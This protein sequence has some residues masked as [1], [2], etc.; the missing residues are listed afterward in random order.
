MQLKNRERSSVRPLSVAVAGILSLAAFA[1]SAQESA[2]SLMLD[3]IVVTAQKRAA[4]LQ[5]VPLSVAAV[6]GEKMVDAGIKDLA[7]MAGYV[8]NFEKADTSIGQYLI[9]RGIG[10]GIN[11]GFEQSVVQY[12]DDVALGRS[13]LARMPFM[14]LDRIEVLR[15]P[16]N[17]LFGKNSIAGALSIVTAKPTS[18]LTGRVGVEYEPEYNGREGNLVI[19]GA[20]SDNIRGRL[21]ARYYEED[22]YFKNNLTGRDE[23][24]RK[25]TAIRGTLA[26]DITDTL[27]ATLKYEHD[28]FDYKGRTDEMLFTY[29]NPAPT[30]PFYGLTYPQIAAALGAMVGQDIGSDDGRQDF[31]RNSNIDEWSNNEVNVATLTANWNLGWSTLTAVSGYA[32]YKIDENNDTDASGIDVF[33]TTQY[34][35]YDQFSQEIRLVSPGGEKIDW[36]VGAYYQDWNLK[37]RA[38]LD[39]DGQNLFTALGALGGPYAPLGALGWVHNWRE[40]SGDSTTWAGFGQGTWNA[41]D[42]LRLT[43]GARYTQEKKSAARTVDIVNAQTGAFNLTQA[44][45]ASAVFGVDFKTL[46]EVTGGLYPIHDISGKRSEDA[47]TPSAIIQYDVN[48]DS[49]LYA[50]VSK[51]YKA[52]GFDARGNKAAGQFEYQNESVL[53]YEAGVKSAFLDGAAEANVALFYSDYKDLQVSQ[54]DGTLGFVVGNAAAATVQGVEVDGRWLITS[55]LTLSGSL[56]Y[57]D[58]SFD[59]YDGAACTAIHAVLTGEKLCDYAGKTNIF[60]PEFTG[61]VSLDWVASLSQSLSLHTTLDANYRS[62]QFVDVTLNPDIKQDAVTKLNARLALEADSW[63]VAVVGKNLTDETVASFITDTPLSNTVGAPAYT[64]Y[65]DRPRT[66]ALQATYKF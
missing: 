17:V 22:G 4:S 25:E 28:T 11:Q 3:E 42:S 13:V 49:M 18:E 51:G 23:A 52:G 12:M 39:T 27:D 14:D 64:G 5:D 63:S 21:A 6:E 62:S 33:T 54:F 40:Y 38:N 65:M 9:I 34:E 43:V 30:S 32:D 36:I 45:I 26:W 59:K 19:S 10:S 66:I 7:D 20:F 57:L 60:A 44:A 47:F 8:P 35:T 15:G 55:G 48:Q 56:G 46:G 29:Q 37:F 58:F 61:S 50:S 16:Q 2:P 24:Q 1:A 31:H 53:S 41:T